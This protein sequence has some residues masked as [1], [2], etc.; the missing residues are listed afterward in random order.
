MRWPAW[1]GRYH[2]CMPDP[3]ASQS[4][5]A[6]GALSSADIRKVARLAR[7]EA[8]D[9]EVPEHSRR[10]SAVLGFMQTLSGLDVSGVEPMTVPFELANVLRDD[11]PGPALD[12]AS[13]MTMVSP[14]GV[15]E[16][17]VRVPRAVGE[18]V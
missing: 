15:S 17:Y 10:L 16:P 2:V 12:T 14:G 7:L 8:A 3:T 4:S 11:E 6:A 1:D 13:L 5:E 18:G 9:D